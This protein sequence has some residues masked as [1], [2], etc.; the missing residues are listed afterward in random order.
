METGHNPRITPGTH[1]LLA[2]Q[3]CRVFRSGMQESHHSA[4]HSHITLPL[5]QSVILTCCISPGTFSAIFL[6]DLPAKMSD[7]G[8]WSGE[9][10]W[11]VN[12]YNTG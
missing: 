9:D 8:D 4:N 3:G 6:V 10:V 5:L 7:A 12:L 11:V 1:S 2:G